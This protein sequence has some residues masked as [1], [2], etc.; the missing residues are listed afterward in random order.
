MLIDK[1][2]TINGY[3]LW[4]YGYGAFK[5]LKP[6]CR[7]L[8]AESAVLLKNEN[9][10]LP[11][12]PQESIA[13]FGRMQLHYYK[14]GTGSGGN[15][16]AETPT[17]M[18]AIQKETDFSIDNV[19]LETYESWVA[20]HPFD[21]G[22]G[23][24]T[25]PFCQEEMPLDGELVN[26]ASKRN[27]TALVVIGRV[28]GEDRDNA[29]E[30]GS[31][32]LTDTEED[33][34]EKVCNAFE[35]VVVLLNVGNIID[36][37]F[38]NRY[39]ISALMY[40][41][42]GGM[43]GTNAIADLLTGRVSPCGK[44][45]DT[46]AYCYEDFPTAKDFGEREVVYQE[47]IFV[48]YRYFE[49][50]AK[51]KVMFPFGFGLSYTSFKT[52]YKAEVKDGTV[53]VNAKVQNTGNH[54]GR[55]VVQIYYSAPQG[56]LGNPLKQLIA[57][58]KTK[59]LEPHETQELTLSFKITDMASYDDNGVT[60]NP[61][62][63]VM[64]KGEF[65]VFAGT[66]V[67][68]C[69]KVLSYTNKETVVTQKLQQAMAP[70]RPFERY[71]ATLGDDGEVK[72]ILSSV[73][74]ITYDVDERS[75]LDRPEDI[76]YTGDRGIKLIDVAEHRNTMEEFIA[77]FSVSAL[78]ELVCGE[79]MS[80]PKVR[81]VGTGAAI[82]GVTESLAN[83]GLPVVCLCDGP[84]G[85]RFQ[86]KATSIPIG[87]ALACT[88]DTEG[89]EELGTLLGIEL[90]AN[91]IDMLL[92]GG[93]N[94]HR[95]PLNGRNF[96]YFSEDPVISGKFSAALTRGIAKSGT[97]TTIK[98]FAANSQEKLRRSTDS[99][100][101]ERALREIYLK[102][103]EIA[104]KEGNVS[105]V[106]T[107]YNRINGSWSASN[108]DLTTTLLRKEWGFNGFVMTDWWAT[109]NWKLSPNS[110]ESLKYMIKAQNDIYMVCPDATAKPHDILEGIESGFITLGDLQ[111][112]AI[113]LVKYFMT[114]PAF[115]K[116]VDGGCQK[117]SF[118]SDNDTTMQ[119]IET[120]TP[121]VKDRE[122]TFSIDAD[123]T[124]VCLNLELTCSADVIAQLPIQLVDNGYNFM[125]IIVNGTDGKIAEA[126]RFITL[127]KGEHKLSF[128]FGD[129][130]NINKVSVKR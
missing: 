82:G 13:V 68:S 79:G 12:K 99:I 84:A 10:V 116:F 90:F 31:F 59:T 60:G 20:E 100:V 80:S 9:E 87:T 109:C 129:K 57:F 112:C 29:N 22:N 63:Y 8:A 65:T 102:G 69:E 35:R 81:R 98:H 113:R 114:T 39:R 7:K 96:E 61:Y 74:Q 128:V 130:V 122:Y 45:A 83:F 120:F 38:L 41:W 76:K 1:N 5:P 70:T 23:W 93:M 4:D 77:Q 26:A 43:E 126:K 32:L 58:Q 95:N 25:E 18:E 111:R 55:E 94:I 110:N 21:N 103:F 50:F 47:D 125:T 64:E 91:D 121:V 67:R 127:K 19:V 54:S 107:S 118:I 44:L 123:S 27:S 52:S 37:S 85:I 72:K 124:K 66:D 119:I 14:S 30:K 88:W 89:V 97:S 86:G 101:S 56:N 75:F 34:L 62:C 33:M 42:Q 106:M 78:C 49:T 15:V 6:L 71:C 117:P 92:G 51:E 28:S 11:L 105:A 108:Y 40:V 53:T 24:A 104:V 73:P 115:L 17:F 46:Q 16:Q 48:G 3:K 36:I 2:K